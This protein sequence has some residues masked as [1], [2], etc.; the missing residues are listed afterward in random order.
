MSDLKQQL[1]RLG[2]RNPSLRKHLRPVLDE[3]TKTSSRGRVSQ[4]IKD[5]PEKHA[6]DDDDL[7]EMLSLIN[8]AALGLE[9][10]E[11]N[12]FDHKSRQKATYAINQVN[13]VNIPLD[14]LKAGRGERK[15]LIRELHKAKKE[16]KGLLEKVDR[17][18]RGD[19]SSA[20]E[21]IED[22]LRIAKRR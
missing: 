1:I 11:D 22:A 13:E 7:S 10:V 15:D 8:D 21:E 14:E 4:D 17:Q 5:M 9:Y 20:L 18:F 19:V 3:I 16:V 12:A 6:L 2:S